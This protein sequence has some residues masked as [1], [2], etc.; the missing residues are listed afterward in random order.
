MLRRLM[1]VCVVVLC[2]VVVVPGVAWAGSGAQWTVSGVSR[3][4]VFAVGSSEDAFVVLVTNTGGGASVGSVTVTDE[5]PEGVVAGPGVTAE[6]E[7]GAAEP[8]RYP[9]YAFSKDCAGTGAGGVSCTYGGVVAPDDTLVLKIP[10]VVLAGAAGSVVNVVRVSGGGAQASGVVETPTVVAES[11]GQARALTPFGMSVG[12]EST[13]LS[14]LQAG[15]HPDI[16]TTFAFNTEDGEGATAGSLKNIVTYE[17]PGV[18]LDLAATPECADDLFLREECPIDTQVGVTTAI[19]DQG[20]G[21]Q[22]YL[23]PVYNLAPEPG[24]IAKIAFYIGS[25]NRYEG[26]VALRAPGEEGAYGGKVV[27]ANNTGGFVDVDGGSL[28]IWGVPASA[29]HDPL[30]WND[31][32]PSLGD[33][34]FDVASDAPQTSYFTNPTACT[35]RPLVAQF[36]VTSWQHPRESESPPVTDMPFGPIVGC[37]GPTLTFEPLLS[38]EVTS[39]GAYAPTGLDFDTRI[40]QT[41]P[42]PELLASSTLKREV[43]TLPEGMTL[44]PSSGAGLEACSEQQY[45]E[46]A[47]PEKTQLEKEQGHGCPSSSKLA[48]VRIQTPLLS[49]EVKGSVYLATPAPRGEPGNNPFN[50][51]LALYLIARIP[52]RGV[53]VKTPG[54]V[55][56]NETTGQ[57]TTSFGLPNTLEPA[58]DELEGGLAPLPFSIAKFEFNQGANAPLV[59]PPTCGDYTVT[60]ALTPWSDPEG[61]PFTPPIPPFPITAN[62]PTSNTPP[63]TPGVTAYPIHA[64]A[65]AYTPLYLKI[66]RSDGEQEITGFSTVFPEGLS[67][68]LSG[69]P[70]CGEGEIQVARGQ[71]GVQAETEPACPAGSEIGYS[72]ADAGVGSVLAQNPG[73]IYLGGP[74]EGAPFS[75]VSVTSAHVGPFDLGTVVVHFPLQINPETAVVSIPAGPADQIPHIIKGIV[76]HVREIRAYI[77]RERFM[78]NPTSCDPLSLSATVIG[79]GANPTDPAGYDPVT[80]TDPF[81]AADCANLRFTP[82]I[83]VSTAAHASKAHGA[84]LFFKIAYPPN[85]IGSQSWFNEAKFDIPKQLPAR[86]T[87]LQKACLAATFQ[88]NP[89]ACPGPSKIGYAVVH[90]PILPVPLEGPVYFVS[91]GGAKFPDAVL[92]LKGDNITITLHGETFINNKTGVTSATFR[93]LPDVPFQSIEVTVPTGPYSEFGVNLPPKDNY[94]FCGQKLTLPT[95]FK[96]SNGTEIHQNTPVTITGCPRKHKN[97]S[98]KHSNKKH[99]SKHKH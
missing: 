79:G 7:L 38:A 88:A 45:A 89:A 32:S 48:T 83:S 74:F 5:L 67:G 55:Q 77:N 8:S 57:I 68:N 42:S 20:E 22:S 15:G 12:G 6:D 13:A 59:T 98:K 28:T 75:V 54:L 71:T 64:N 58:G 78:L 97:T 47:T 29:I 30:R 53:L 31:E 24:E 70:E 1:L 81:Q 35:S 82:T 87:T 21:E 99:N 37:D 11:V 10:V 65:G 76:V 34:H 40:P 62:C 80:V 3:P 16:T 50:S 93:S 66:S 85:P 44:N 17:P 23:E 73:K 61:A 90:T 63:F 4:S 26:D 51:L 52:N 49:E 27:F 60:A 56:L 92:L 72:L 86:L 19:V 94:D 39:D 95:L 18:A 41:Y 69:V 96:A 9:G 91:Y 84:G 46:E 14:S 36:R 25:Q 43:V 2:V 33:R